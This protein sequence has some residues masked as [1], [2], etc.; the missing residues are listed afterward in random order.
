MNDTPT[1]S[2]WQ[3][4][5]FEVRTTL[6]PLDYVHLMTVV[7]WR[8]IER[9]VAWLAAIGMSGMA[10]IAA[11]IAS[12][13]L[14]GRLPAFA[15]WDWSLAFVLAG[16]FVGLLLY[17]VFVMGPYLDSMFYGQPIGMGATTIMADATGINSTS[18]GIGV[19]VPWN[20][21]E[22][23]IVRDQ[24]LFLMFARLAGVIVPRRA[25]ANDDEAQRFADFVRSKAQRAA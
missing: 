7:R 20:K 19:N 5:R 6:E 25:F 11:L 8:P 14:I 22:A 2:P 17:K 3:T 21:V 1:P 10:A 15:Y 24:H 16:A 23:V 12:E 9:V 13:P 4:T 18:A